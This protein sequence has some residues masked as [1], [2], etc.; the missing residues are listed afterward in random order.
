MARREFTEI[1]KVEFGKRI[2]AMVSQGYTDNKIASELKLHRQTV[3][4]FKQTQAYSKALAEISKVAMERAATSIKAQLEPAAEKA[5]KTLMAK[6]ESGDLKAVDMVF[7]SLKLYD[8]GA[9][10]GA[11]T[12]ITI[13][14]PGQAKEPKQVDSSTIEIKGFD[15]EAN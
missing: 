8:S 14:M 6:L 5:I 12:P 7:K 9:D 2:A 13:I 3:H 11:N 15:D 1:E 4:N 10:D